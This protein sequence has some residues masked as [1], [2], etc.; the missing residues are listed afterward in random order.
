MNIWEG[1]SLPL[2]EMAPAFGVRLL[3]AALVVI[4]DSTDFRKQGFNGLL[5]DQCRGIQIDYQSG[6]E[7]PHSKGSADL[8]TGFK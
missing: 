3:G 2:L 7:L 4:S 5:A 8:R 1:K 6:T